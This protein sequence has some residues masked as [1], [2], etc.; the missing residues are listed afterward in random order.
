M[1]KIGLL[2]TL[3]YIGQILIGLGA[4]FIILFQDWYRLLGFIPYIIGYALNSASFEILI[5]RL[6]K[7]TNTI[8][9]INK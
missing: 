6:K 3:F 1:K 8:E 5:S 7:C 2:M 9:D 4:G